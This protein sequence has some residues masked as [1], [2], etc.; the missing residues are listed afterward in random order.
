MIRIPVKKNSI[1]ISHSS[2]DLNTASTIYAQLKADGFNPWMAVNDIPA[3]A[4]YA[5]M[6]SEALE[7]A[8]AIV[9]IMTQ[10][11][12]DSEHV[13][14]EVNIAIDRK[15]PLFPVNLSGQSDI[16]P[17]LTLDWKYWLTI[18]QILNCTSTDSAT[19]EIIQAFRRKGLELR[20]KNETST[21]ASS[22]NS[23][24][25]PM[26]IKANQSKQEE[27]DRKRRERETNILRERIG[28]D[29]GDQG[30]IENDEKKRLEADED[31][32]SKERL[33]KA[34]RI[35]TARPKIQTA[36]KVANWL[37]ELSDWL[38]DIII[39]SSPEEANFNLEDFHLSFKKNF[40]VDLRGIEDLAAETRSRMGR[41]LLYIF[42]L[43]ASNPVLTMNQP[44]RAKRY[45]DLA[46]EYGDPWAFLAQGEW[47]LARGEMLKAK[48]YFLDPSQKERAL[49]EED[50]AGEHTGD[51][52]DSSNLMRAI[53]S[54]LGSMDLGSNT[55]SQRLELVK[56]FK[57]S[58]KWFELLVQLS[59]SKIKPDTLQKMFQE[60]DQILY[61][62]SANPESEVHLAPPLK[63]KWK[64]L[65]AMVLFRLERNTAGRNFLRGIDD[66]SEGYR[67]ASGQIYGTFNMSTGE[68][69]TLMLEL[70]EVMD[71]WR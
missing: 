14:R 57:Y 19:S 70:V 35:E 31:R 43:L 36:E 1:F 44:E 37:E 10:A 13:K 8:S 11:A 17:L 68:G 30:K 51:L 9:I 62:D 25:I 52:V 15:I 54:P 55:K 61:K 71:T 42:R 5:Y 45:L 56:E 41:E 6:L 46:T 67:Q 7:A 60:I 63:V 26:G 34:K 50:R 65:G 53:N 28:K 49:R 18:V 3:G 16:L 12:I 58:W 21:S 39:E 48:K 27:L 4:N 29:R 38:T 40:I 32:Q 64:L 24:K 59:D 20:T 69:K 33:D 2:A 66:K 23:V 47:L 22:Q